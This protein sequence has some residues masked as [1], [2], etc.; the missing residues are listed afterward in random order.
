LNVSADYLLGRTDD[1]IDYTNPDL[2]ADLSGAV[3]DAH[4]GDVRQALAYQR[5]VQ[6]DVRKENMQNQAGDAL[7]LT[8]YHRLSEV[9]RAKV[10]AYIDGLLSSD[11][12]IQL[13][14]KKEA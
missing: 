2:I 4:N 12:Y 10:S 7:L 13:E 5:A 9:D 1:P 6:D 8:K 11:I 3:L 14:I